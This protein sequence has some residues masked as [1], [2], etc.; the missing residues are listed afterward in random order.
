MRFKTASFA[1]RLKGGEAADPLNRRQF[2]NFGVSNMG[3]FFRY[4]GVIG[5]FVA[6]ILKLDVRIDKKLMTPRVA[7]FILGG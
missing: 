5:D 3:H 7:L 4:L 1:D 6:D 2:R